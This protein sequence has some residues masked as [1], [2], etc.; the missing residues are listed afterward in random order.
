MH[1]Y[2]AVTIMKQQL[3]MTHNRPCN[4]PTNYGELLAKYSPI[5]R[6]HLCTMHRINVYDE[7]VG[8]LR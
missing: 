6:D 4:Y 1:V 2:V 7:T 5:S 8:G 3:G